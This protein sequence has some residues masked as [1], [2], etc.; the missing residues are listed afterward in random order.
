M[1]GIEPSTSCLPD[2]NL[3][4]RKCLPNNDQCDSKEADY[5]PDYSENPEMGSDDR[6]QALADALRG[7][8]EDERA[9]LADMLKDEG[10]DNG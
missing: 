6:L 5:S 4:V 3:P 2:N 1:N 7:L 9:K 8:S 10:R